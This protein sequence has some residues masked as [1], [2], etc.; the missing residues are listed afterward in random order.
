MD[1]EREEQ[2]RVVLSGE[3]VTG[4]GN[5]LLSLSISV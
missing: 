4:M 2:A 5:L 3:T 1:Q